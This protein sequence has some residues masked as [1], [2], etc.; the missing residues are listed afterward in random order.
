MMRAL[1]VAWLAML[2][3]CNG[4]GD[5]IWRQFNNEAD[6]LTIEIVGDV[7]PVVMSE[8]TSNTG[9]VIIGTAIVDP[10]SGPVG[11]AHRLVLE[12]DDEWQERIGRAT[13]TS[14]GERGE[15]EYDLRQDAA[16]HGVFDLTLTSLGEP[17]EIRT[18]TWI[19]TLWEPIENDPVE[20]VEEDAQ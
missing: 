2:A 10:G 13:I 18:D 19:M 6:T 12:I 7:G 11:T 14:T 20:F 9:E 15:E 5:I 4:N 17:G 1:P 3:A 8:I 16:D